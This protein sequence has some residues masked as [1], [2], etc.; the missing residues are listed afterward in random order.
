MDSVPPRQGCDDY[1]PAVRTEPDDCNPDGDCDN[2]CKPVHPRLHQSLA[3]APLVLD[4]KRG[5]ELR[6]RIGRWVVE[7]PE[8]RLAVEYRQREHFR[9]GRSRPRASRRRRRSR[10]R[11]V[12]VRA[13]ARPGRGSGCGELHGAT[14]HPRANSFGGGPPSG[15]GARTRRRVWPSPKAV[16]LPNGRLRRAVRWRTLPEQRQS[17]A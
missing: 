16:A 5:L 9:L 4:E 15:A 14:L 11:G 6:E 1:V 10:P 2:T 13:R 7:C 3:H 17:A 8:D 12:I